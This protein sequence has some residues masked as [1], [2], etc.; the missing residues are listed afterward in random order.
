MEGPGWRPTRKRQVLIGSIPRSTFPNSARTLHV[1]EKP[2][3][4]LSIE[5]VAKEKNHLI[6]QKK[7]TI[8]FRFLQKVHTFQTPPGREV[9]LVFHSGQSPLAQPNNLGEGKIGSGRW[10]GLREVKKEEVMRDR[11]GLGNGDVVVWLYKCIFR[12][13]LLLFVQQA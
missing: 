2:R 6:N 8:C 13:L 9:F 5:G 10:A 12:F 4:R 1:E 11:G 7:G 3:N